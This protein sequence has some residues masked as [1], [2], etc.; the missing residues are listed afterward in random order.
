M[1]RYTDAEQLTWLK[2]CIARPRS[3]KVSD[4]CE[5]DGRPSSGSLYKWAVAHFGKSLNY[6]EP[7]EVRDKLKAAAV[8]AVANGDLA[9]EAR[10]L[11]AR[12]IASNQHLLDAIARRDQIILDLLTELDEMRN[13]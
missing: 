5:E 10:A 11:V 2:R 7:G 1:E 12:P 9:Q 8:H 4:W 3:E 13:A 6:V